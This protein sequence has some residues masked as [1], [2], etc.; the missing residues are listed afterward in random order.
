MTLWFYCIEKSYFLPESKTY[1]LSVAK[2]AIK[3]GRKMLTKGG[4][5]SQLIHHFQLKG[6]K[7]RHSVG[8]AG[9]TQLPKH[10]HTYWFPRVCFLSV[11]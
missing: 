7:V 3:R 4:D 5:T 9:K 2:K 1:S 11:Y 6:Y 8:H 10:R